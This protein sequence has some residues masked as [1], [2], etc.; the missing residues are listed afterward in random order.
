MAAASTTS[1]AMNPLRTTAKP[2]QSS[3]V[4]GNPLWRSAGQEARAADAVAPD[5]HERAAGERRI[6]PSRIVDEREREGRPDETNVADRAAADELEEPRRLRMV[7][8]HERL[9]QQAA[10]SLC[11]GERA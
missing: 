1:A 9:H 11:G 3:A 7:A 8:P 5:V 4:L 2:R 6:D 10:V